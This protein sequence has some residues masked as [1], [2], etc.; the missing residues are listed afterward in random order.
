MGLV[1]NMLD[2]SPMQFCAVK[3]NLI[4]SSVK[5]RINFWHKPF[6]KSEFNFIL[7]ETVK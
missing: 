2:A 4:Y 6:K 3:Y 1:P 7:K 5:I